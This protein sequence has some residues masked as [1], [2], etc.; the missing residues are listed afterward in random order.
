MDWKRIFWYDERGQK[1]KGLANIN[2]L[3]NFVSLEDKKG[4]T[5]EIL[6]NEDVQ[7]GMTLQE[8]YDEIPEDVSDYILGG[9][10]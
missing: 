7:N 9:R 1:H 6:F 4:F 5:F 2:Y 10:S 8:I 3:D